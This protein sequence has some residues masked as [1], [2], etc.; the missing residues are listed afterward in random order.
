VFQEYRPTVHAQQTRGALYTS[1]YLYPSEDLYPGREHLQALLGP[2]KWDSCALVPVEIQADGRI[3]DLIGKDRGWFEREATDLLTE[4]GIR[5]ITMH[6]LTTRDRSTTQ[7]LARA[8]YDCGIAGLRYPSN[9][10]EVPCIALFEGRAHFVAAGL[11]E[12][13][14]PT[15]PA[16]RVLAQLDVVLIRK[17]AD[18]NTDELAARGR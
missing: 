2:S 18:D 17:E 14:T 15:M 6:E 1:E 11:A 3:L 13:V 10:G 12:P 8:A 4:L 7:R 5:R 9:A 16:H